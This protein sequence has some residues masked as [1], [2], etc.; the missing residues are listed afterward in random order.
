[1]VRGLVAQHGHEHQLISSGNYFAY[2]S[3]I[4]EKICQFE[5]YF[6]LTGKFL[7]T[8]V[9]KYLSKLDL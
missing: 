4:M 7:P 2:I 8:F 3:I 5:I 1:M 9:G 6:W